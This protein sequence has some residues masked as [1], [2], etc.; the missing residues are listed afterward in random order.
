MSDM[1]LVI[2]GAA[3]RMGQALIRAIQDIPGVRVAANGDLRLEPSPGG[4]RSS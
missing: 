3:G 1:G 4:G 2:V